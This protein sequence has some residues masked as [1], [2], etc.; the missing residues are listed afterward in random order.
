MRSN[1]SI[2]Q[3]ACALAK[4]Q[5]ELVNPPKSLTA[6][7]DGDGNGSPGQS[8]RYAP[9]SAG[10]DVVRKTLGKHEIAI[11][12]TTD[13]DQDSGLVILTTTLAHGSGEW[14]AA[15]WPVCHIA[16]LPEPKLMGAA[17][18]Y[19]RRYGLFTLVGLAGE[20]DLDALM[21]AD[22]ACSNG[23]VAGDPSLSDGGN[24]PARRPRGRSRKAPV[25][26]APNTS[27][28]F[29]AELAAITGADALLRW[30]VDAL[31]RRNRL[32]DAERI[33]LDQAFLARAEALGADP[34]LLVAPGLHI[35]PGAKAAPL[36]SSPAA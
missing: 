10:L 21:I 31:P 34:D 14:I 33:Q 6:H 32:S 11:L 25:Q 36:D 5:I 3:L 18:T 12:Q 1:D 28:D 26:T 23:G 16:D 9:L 17:L 35:S 29:A 2:A 19:A 15:R 20:D 22:A 8:Y 27:Q 13:M 7:F 24:R 4:A 30:A